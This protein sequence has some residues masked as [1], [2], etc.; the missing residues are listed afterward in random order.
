MTQTILILHRDCSEGGSVSTALRRDDSDRFRVENLD[1]AAAGEQRLTGAD[2]MHPIVAVLLDLDLRDTQGI[3][4]FERIFRAAPHIPILVLCT[5]NDESTAR[6]A[7]HR[8]AQDYLLPS[9]VD[10]YT[11]RKAVRLMLERASLAEI[12]YR[13][14]ETAQ[15]TLD[16]IADAVI[17]ADV[18]G[19]TTYLNSVAEQLTGWRNAEAA[20]RPVQEI[21]RLIDSASRAVVPSPLADAISRDTAVGVT[22]NCVLVR[23]D[24]VEAAIEDS[25]APIHDR[26]GQVTGAVMVFRDVKDARA[27]SMKMA[28]L[29]QHDS[30]TDLPNRGL[31]KDRLEQALALAYRRRLKMAVLF[32][33]LDRFKPI[34]DALGHAAGDHVLREVARRLL[35]CVRQSDTVSRR[36]GDEFVVVL[37]EVA[38]AQDATLAAAKLLAAISRPYL[39]DGIEIHVTASIGIAT[40]PDGGR[41]AELLLKNADIA[42]YSAKD[43]GGNG[44]CLFQPDMSSCAVERR[45]LESSIRDAM[46]RGELTL[47]YQPKLNLDDGT[48]IGAE[49]L[50]RWRHPVIGLV[51]PHQF[52]PVAESCGIIVPIGRW[53]LRE[54]CRQARLWQVQGLPLVRIAVNVSSSDLDAEDFVS[55][56]AI[57]LEETGLDATH[58]ELELTE[59]FLMRDSE[60]IGDA[61]QAL[62]RMGVQI[63]LDDFG[64]GYSSLS[65]VS[66]FPIDTLKIDGSFVR[67]MTR[68]AD[69]AR[70]VS[71]VIGM[72]AN[73]GM[74][75]VAEGVETLEQLTLLREQ[76]CA[77]GQG[78]YF[79]PA[80]PAD[81]F[82]AML[83]HGWVTPALPSARPDVR[84]VAQPRDGASSRQARR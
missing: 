42:M 54:A 30:L 77:E 81:E 78:H 11:L 68:S 35:S 10:A 31:L 75:V 76:G 72:G 83:A 38:Q 7:V 61:L 65:Y 50:I 1:S 70:I 2:R 49:A 56:V 34:N 62:R 15:L 53:A 6:L 37:P 12:V 74:R 9:Q 13:Q 24:G 52:I 3:E 66:R 73:L 58:L 23:R 84:A 60:S 29:A 19:N 63:A 41:D 64:T 48:I 32:V 43:M 51:T 47:Y 20:G 39:H 40:Y 28:H 4:T 71:T 5:V 79:S 14:K 22:P 45:S 27:L 8:G 59:A 44:H 36:G 69:D 16:S 67:E 26:H 46:A 57:I 82:A 55:S 80:V 33:D 25:A 17:T 21:L 18:A